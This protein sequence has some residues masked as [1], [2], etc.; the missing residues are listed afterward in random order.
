M[1]DLPKVFENPIN[2][3]SGNNK[4]YSYQT[5]EEE[6]KR[7]LDNRPIDQK[8]N[9]IFSS[10]HYIYKIKVA[11]IRDGKQ[12]NKILIGRNKDTIITLENEQIPI[13]DIQDIYLIQ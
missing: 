13:K 10:D 9:S 8:I 4:T 5:H 6:I 11:I 1:K 2:E 12:E 3:D 7:P